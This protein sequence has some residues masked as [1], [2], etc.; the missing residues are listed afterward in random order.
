MDDETRLTIFWIAFAVV[1][2]LFII[3]IGVNV[4]IWWQGAL[5]ENGRR[6]EKRKLGSFIRIVFKGVFSKRFWM[7]LKAF[8]LDAALQRKLFKEDFL[9]WLGHASLSISFFALF[10]LSAF[11]GFFEEGLHRILGVDTPFVRTVIDKNTPIMALLNE[12]LG[13]IIVLGLLI[14]VFRRY[15]LR[16][17]QLSASV[18]DNA[19][20]ILLLILVLTSYPV[21]SFRYLRDGFPEVGWHSF[22]GYQLGLLLEPLN[23]NW[24]AVH[25]W[26]FMVHF[27]SAAALLLY[28]PF[29]KFVHVFISPLVIAING[30]A[31]EAA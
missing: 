5:Y 16:P 6:V 27:G 2:L 23:W 1:M 19:V 15:I 18:M 12:A 7:A 10:L 21:E 13:I 26:A 29:S 28:L 17:K 4:S 20:I 14:I 11:T 8:V 24:Q 25:F 9:R 22:F 30:V 31:E 3:A